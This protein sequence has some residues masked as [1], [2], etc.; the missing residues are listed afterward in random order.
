MKRLQNDADDEEYYSYSEYVSDGDD[1]MQKRILADNR[2][3]TETA[4][5]LPGSTSDNPENLSTF[6]FY[7]RRLK[8][9][10]SKHNPENVDRV[11]EVLK[12]Y[13][14]GPGISV[15]FEALVKKY[16]PS[17]KRDLV[18]EERDEDSCYSYSDEDF[19]VPKSKSRERAELEAKEEARTLPKDRE[20]VENNNIVKDIM[21]RELAERMGERPQSR[22]SQN[23]SYQRPLKK[24][25]SFIK[26][27]RWECLSC[28][29]SNEK[30]FQS[31]EMC[32]S[33]N[34]NILFEKE[35][36]K[37]K[38]LRQIGNLDFSDFEKEVE[39]DKEL[40]QIGNLDF[41][42][43]NKT[44]QSFEFKPTEKSAGS[45]DDDQ[46]SYYSDDDEEIEYNENGPIT[47]AGELGDR[48]KPLATISE[49]HPI[50]SSHSEWSTASTDRRLSEGNVI[51]DA[52]TPN[53]VRRR[54]HG[55]Y[56]ARGMFDKIRDIDKTMNLYR[57]R[58]NQ[59][60]DDVLGEQ[61]KE[62][63]NMLQGNDLKV[64]VPP[65]A[66]GLQFKSGPYGIGAVVAGFH[67]GSRD[68]LGSLL[69]EFGV[70][71][72]MTITHVDGE[73]LAER[74]FR[75][76]LRFL[77]THETE[78]QDR[79][80]TFSRL[81]LDLRQQKRGIDKSDSGKEKEKAAKKIQAVSRGQNSR[82]ILRK[83]EKA[84]KKIQAVSRGQNSRRILRKKEK[85]AKKIQAVSRGQNSRRILRKKEKAAKKIQ[86]V[87]RGQNSRRILRKKEKAAKKIQAVSRGQNSRR[88]LRK[89]EKAAKKIQAVSRGQ[90]SRLLEMQRAA[91]VLSRQ[92]RD[93]E[94]ERNVQVVQ[95]ALR[96]EAE[97][98]AALKEFNA[99]EKDREENHRKEA[100]AIQ[101]QALTRGKNTRK[102]YN[103]QSKDTTNS[104]S[105]LALS[106]MLEQEK[107]AARHIQALVRG[108][109]VRKTTYQMMI[110]N[111]EREEAIQKLQA[112]QR[113][114]ICRRAVKEKRQKKKRLDKS[115]REKS[116]TKLQTFA[117]ERSRR[118]RETN[119]AV[120]LQRT[121]RGQQGRKRARQRSAEKERSV[122]ATKIQRPFRQLF[123]TRHRD[124]AARSIQK[125]MRGKFLIVFS[126]FSNF[127]SDGIYA[128]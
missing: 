109:H 14:Q 2:E 86:A 85:A 110:F 57:G 120:K 102:L 90:N 9:F 15:L 30:S 100:A 33:L 95:R 75:D 16:G 111:R 127:F 51:I 66:L 62:E 128:D 104:F 20:N 22:H 76:I 27:V 54:L 93:R 99:F 46:Y 121:T 35:V 91:P 84:A 72:G 60:L 78:K 74:L 38:E 5:S 12:A 18:L 108:S 32:G 1:D 92:K 87:S 77:R 105:T 64:V 114:R 126:N 83:K 34:K 97:R 113:G 7:R 125:A 3:S 42:D 101:L 116:A 45:D 10:Y 106:E 53:E 52:V 80:L 71:C 115:R 98:I 11:D 4:A 47:L 17:S 25:I 123:Q 103:K 61:N 117:R 19:P 6:K 49:G 63:S 107:E 43:P 96:D 13:V 40:R 69:R 119:A 50:T 112:L 37:D 118:R 41:S 73:F 82:R 59:L 88:I 26:D 36:E 23:E 70:E 65:G 21:E 94:K 31:C 29:Y 81:N 48:R 55:F 124:S 68:H 122:S 24:P 8:R 58:E 56:A 79:E 28:G 67:K 44:F 39:K 89:K